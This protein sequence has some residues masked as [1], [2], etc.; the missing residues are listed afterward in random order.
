[1]IISFYIAIS[2]VP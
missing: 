2:R 1:M